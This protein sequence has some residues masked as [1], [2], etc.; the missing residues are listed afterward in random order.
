MKPLPV[1]NSTPARKG[2]GLHY[3]HVILVA[4]VI[5]VV[6]CLG[7]ARFGYNIVVPYMKQGLGLTNAQM[8]FIGTS[9]LAG[10]M[11]FTALS[12]FLAVKYGPRRVIICAMLLTGLAMALTGLVHSYVAAAALQLFVGLATAGANIPVMGLASAWFSRRRRAMATGIFVGGVGIGAAIS[13]FVVPRIMSL[14]PQVGWRYSWALLGGLVIVCGLVGYRFLRNSPAELGLQP[15]GAGPGYDAPVTLDTAAESREDRAPGWGS[16]Y[17]LRPLWYLALVYFTFGFSYIIYGTFSSQTIV[18]DWGLDPALA[19]RVWVVAGVFAI[20]S[21][22]FWGIL[23]DR[24]GRLRILAVIYCLL[25]LCNFTFALFTGAVAVLWFSAML[26]GLTQT[27]I[28]SIVAA[29]C[30]DWVGDRLAPAALG[31][32]AMFFAAGQAVG[33]AVAGYLADIFASFRIPYLVA[34]L[35]AGLGS[36]GCLVLRPPGKTG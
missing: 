10:Y 1:P 18:Q 7:L 20:F 35:V 9:G 19:G 21:G 12:G 16:V 15:I 29:I 32:V 30:G 13:G 31:F 34:A 14:W 24:F 2:A 17:G 36:L 23:A 4:G 6:G 22:L 26:F 3:G 11:G 33:P 8:G 27:A 5:T 25:A 28:A